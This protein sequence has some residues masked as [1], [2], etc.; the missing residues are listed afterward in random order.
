MIGGRLSP[1]TGPL[2]T[3]LKAVF[4]KV[5]QALGQEGKQISAEAVQAVAE[6]LTK[7][8]VKIACQAS[9]TTTYNHKKTMGVKEVEAA[10]VMLYDVLAVNAGATGAASVQL[11]SY[12]TDKSLP[13]AARAGTLFSPA[14][15]RH[16]LEQHH[17]GPIAAA[18]PIYLAGALKYIAYELLEAICQRA[19]RRVQVKHVE[20]VLAK[21]ATF[22]VL[23]CA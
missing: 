19:P 1:K 16:F 9:Q 20:D 5:K 23:R 15:I 11:F 12:G 2:D 22:R 3:A 13:V 4:T 10:M 17:R 21:N 18:T 8:V 7:T 14:R 6:V